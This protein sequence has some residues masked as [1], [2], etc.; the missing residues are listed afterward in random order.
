MKKPKV[1]FKREILARFVMTGLQI[2]NFQ[3]I[4]FDEF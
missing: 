1:K 3:L 4:N 2:R